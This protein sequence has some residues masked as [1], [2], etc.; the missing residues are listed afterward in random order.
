MLA[1]IAWIAAFYQMTNH[2]VYK[3]LLF[4]GAGAIDANAGTRD[5]DRLG[6]LIKSMPWIAMTF[7]IGALSIAAFPPLSGFASE[8]LTLQSLLQSAA[9]ASRPVKVVFAL[10]GAGLALTAGLAVT[11][12]AKTYAMSFLGMPRSDKDYKICSRLF[13]HPNCHGAER[14]SLC[15]TGSGPHL[16]DS[17]LWASRRSRR[18]NWCVRGAR[19]SLL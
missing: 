4:F 16:R 15:P 18:G 12:F 5:M 6:G 19:A 9:L 10:C 11:C 2:S 7:L 8:W 14:R 3:S 1:G 13:S 17:G